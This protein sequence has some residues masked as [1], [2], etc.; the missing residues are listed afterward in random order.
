VSCL[1]FRAIFKDIES[2]L[3]LTMRAKKRK[4]MPK[5]KQRKTDARSKYTGFDALH[6]S[7]FLE[8]SSVG[9]LV[10]KSSL[11]RKPSVIHI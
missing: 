7:P 3:S 4:H 2:S 11:S 9:L 10:K 8:W 5:W 1:C 6:S